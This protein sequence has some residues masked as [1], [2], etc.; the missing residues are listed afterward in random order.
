MAFDPHF[1][2]RITQI[3]RDKN[4]NFEEKRMFGGIAF[5]V[6]EKMCVGIIKNNLM[7]RT[8]PEL[9]EEI[10]TRDGCTPMDFTKRRMKGF[11]YIEPE[12]IDMDEDLAD[13]IQVA[14]DYNP[15]AKKSKK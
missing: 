11:V 2:D 4:V 13:W 3:L 9:F 5:M 15:K 12:A 10:I 1:A 6:D 8:D 7:L 14:L